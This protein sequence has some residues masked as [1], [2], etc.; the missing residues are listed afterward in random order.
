MSSST[1]IEGL[2]FPAPIFRIVTD[3]ATGSVLV[4]CRHAA[5]RTVELFALSLDSSEEL[6][7]VSDLE[8]WLGVEAMQNGQVL[9]HHFEDPSLPVHHGLEMRSLPNFELLWKAPE[10]RL[11]GWGKE[12]VWVEMSGKQMGLHPKMGH[13]VVAGSNWDPEGLRAWENERGGVQVPEMVTAEKLGPRALWE[14]YPPT[15][16]SVFYL[17]AADH[18][19]VA[20]HTGEFETGFDLHLAIFTP[21]GQLSDHF[22]LE[23]GLASMIPEPFF[24]FQDQIV[25]MEGRQS[26]HWTR[27]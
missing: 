12:K 21:D 4:E 27:L 14:E 19:L 26:L 10:A 23:E 5:E 3:A 24:L 17:Q 16:A 1:T 9:L 7:Q 25:W 13:E 15:A 18:E 22:Y 11:L 2:D 20:W 8:W 6:Q